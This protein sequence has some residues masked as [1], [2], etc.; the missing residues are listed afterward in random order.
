MNVMTNIS[1]QAHTARENA[2]HDSGRFGEQEHSAPEVAVPAYQQSIDEWQGLLADVN[3]MGGDEIRSLDDATLTRL[4]EYLL[5]AASR[6]QA[7][8]EERGN[9]T[10]PYGSDKTTERLEVIDY[11]NVSTAQL[12]RVWSAANDNDDVASVLRDKADFFDQIDEYATSEVTDEQKE[13][14]WTRFV[15]S[16]DFND[17][18]ERIERADWESWTNGVADSLEAIGVEV[19]R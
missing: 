8:A 11:S 12:G 10:R 6:V 14:A 4:H 13:D 5:S 19:D 18:V 15:D 16:G 2:R 3:T 9:I 1:T 17:H 7:A